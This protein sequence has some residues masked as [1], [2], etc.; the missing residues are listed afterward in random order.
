MQDDC[1][2]IPLRRARFVEETVA[3]ALYDK[4]RYLRLKEETKQRA[5]IW[6]EGNPD[7]NRENK[8]RW[9]RSANAKAY[10]QKRYQERKEEKKAQSRE[11]RSRNPDKVRENNQRNYT[12]DLE[13][14]KRIRREYRKNN[15]EAHAASNSRRRARIVGSGGSHTTADVKRIWDRQKHKCN[16]PSCTNPIADSGRHKFHLDHIQALKNGGSDAPDNL[17]CLCGPCNTRK[18]AE[19]EYIWAQREMGTLFVK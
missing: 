12:R 17:Q 14:S 4:A 19:D 18:N 11:W 16:V 5:K 13:Y 7:R 8:K 2:Q 10:F 9:V 1:I 6:R 15:P 3:K